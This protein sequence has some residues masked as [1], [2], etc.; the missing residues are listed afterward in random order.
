ML[1]PILSSFSSFY[2]CG[3]PGSCAA[4]QQCGVYAAV[5]VSHGVCLQRGL[6]VLWSVHEGRVRAGES[7]APSCSS[8]G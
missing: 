8:P 4:Q 6:D 7:C 2:D 1:S 3:V 5:A